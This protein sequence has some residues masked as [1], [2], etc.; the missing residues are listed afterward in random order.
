[1]EYRYEKKTNNTGLLTCFYWHLQSWCFSSCSCTSKLTMLNITAV[2]ALN[3][4]VTHF[5]SHHLV[6]NL[7]KHLFKLLLSKRH[8]SYRIFCI[9]CPTEICLSTKKKHLILLSIYFKCVNNILVTYWRKKRKLSKYKSMYNFTVFST[10]SS[11]IFIYIFYSC[12]F[13][14]I[15]KYLHSYYA[16]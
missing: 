9:K 13:V 14:Q 11:F 8:S 7:L 10:G 1:M 12:V 3:T 6:Q 2:L 16:I 4:I 15:I 5:I